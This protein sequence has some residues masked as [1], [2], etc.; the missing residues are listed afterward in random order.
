MNEQLTV[1]KEAEDRSRVLWMV[2]LRTMR[3]SAADGIGD[4]RQSYCLVCLL[5]MAKVGSDE[6]W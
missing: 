5:D 6:S 2:A 1:H 4:G 3:A